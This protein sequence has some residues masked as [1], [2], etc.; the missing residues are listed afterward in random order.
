MHTF[1]SACLSPTISSVFPSSNISLEVSQALQAIVGQIRVDNTNLLTDILQGKARLPLANR[2]AMAFLQ[3]RDKDLLRVREL[4]TAGQRPSLKRDNASVKI[5]FRADVDTSVDRLGCII[6]TKQNRNNL[7]RRELVAVPNSVSL[8]ILYS[9]HINLDHPTTD[10]LHQVVDTRFFIHDIVNKCKEISSSCTL[11][12]SVEPIPDE[13][14]QF[15]HNAVPDHPGESFTVDVMKE[16]KK[17]VLVAVDN[18]S[19]YVATTFIPSEKEE[20]LRNGVL[21]A[22]TPFMANSLTRIRVDRAPGFSKM[23]GQEQA[24]KKLGLDIE[25]GHAKNKNSLALVDQKIK[26]LRMALKRVSPSPNVLNQTCL[27]R[28]TTI[29][30]EKIRHHKLSAKEIHF[31]REGTTNKP[32]PLDDDKI[33]ES[34]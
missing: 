10:Q 11:C 31:G 7:V 14:H 28:A 3:S 17:L 34:I 26:E 24:M 27:S 32:I 8:G 19:A 16:N 13:I 18:F 33:A 1:I 22:V 15:T 2:Q 12:T 4:L 25:L 5:Y 21:S 23:S 20:D 9:L 29:I 6:V 30:N